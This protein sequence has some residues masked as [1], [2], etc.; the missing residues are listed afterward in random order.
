MAPA[1]R[2]LASRVERLEQASGHGSRVAPR[3]Y[4][5]L[6]DQCDKPLLGFRVR[7]GRGVREVLRLQGESDA[8]LLDRA[9]A[10]AD[11]IAGREIVLCLEELRGP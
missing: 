10:T 5:R 7:A 9:K 1:N 2:S 4:V 8:G 3:I 11:G 6:L